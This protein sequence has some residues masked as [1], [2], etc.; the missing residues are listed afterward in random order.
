MTSLQTT[1]CILLALVNG[2]TFLLYG[3]DKRCAKKGA[4]RTPEKTLLGFSAAFG[5]LGAFAGMRVFHHKTLKPAFRFSVPAMLAVQVI[6]LI[7]V[8]PKL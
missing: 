1:L 2:A 5:A 8:F 4:W 3:W 6:I 7:F